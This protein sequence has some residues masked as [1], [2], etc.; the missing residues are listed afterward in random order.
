[1]IPKKIEKQ[2]V[3]LW[4][5]VGFIVNL[6]QMIEY[7]LANILSANEI[8]KEFEHRDSMTILEFNDLA[9]ESNKWLD[10]LGKSTMGSVIKRA[11]EVKYFTD[12]AINILEN[13]LKRRNHIAH[14]L[15]VDDLKDK[16]LETNPK[17]YYKYL[18]ETID[19]M[20]KTNNSLLEI[21]K[22]QREEYKTIY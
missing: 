14:Q 5:K 2:L 4:G 13:V 12:E 18:E 22:Q 6:S 10:I 8:L 20:H 3:H 7:N 17:H 19:L 16:H 15:F 21:S 11:K 9:K 1:M